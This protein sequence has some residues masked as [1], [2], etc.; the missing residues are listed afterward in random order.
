VHFHWYFAEQGIALEDHK[1]YIRRL[2]KEI[3]LFI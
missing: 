2:M 1:V 3:A